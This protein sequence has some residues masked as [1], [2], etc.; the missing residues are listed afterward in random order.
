MQATARAFWTTGPRQGEIR[1]A[2]LPP[3]APGH[4]EVA[5]LFSGISRGTEAIV[6]RNEVPASQHAVMR[7]PFQ[8]GGFPAPVKYGY[9]AVGRVVSGPPHLRD[10]IV[11]ALHPHQDLFVVP[12]SAAI[13]LPENVPPERAVLAAN[14]ETALN[15]I[16]DSDV[17]AGDRIAVIGAG[18]VGLLVAYLAA[19]LPAAEVTVIDID[20][21]K[22]AVARALGIPLTAAAATDTDGSFDLVIHASGNPAGLARAVRLAGFEATI[23]EMSWYGSECVTL[24][25][26]EHFHS[27]R[28]VIRS[29]QVGAVAPAQRARWTPRRRLATALGLLADDRLDLLI[30]GESRFEDLPAVMQ[31][32]A[33]GASRAICHRIRY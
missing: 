3:C 20:P 19:R 26:G 25:L 13:P 4:V 9:A 29:S 18:A 24:P 12:E 17:R 32:L 16:W 15:G 1:S 6:F 23:L 5:T 10:R 30:S 14:M 22:A 31:T 27:R 11:F 21:A 8:E 2:E 28:L 33:E 7:C